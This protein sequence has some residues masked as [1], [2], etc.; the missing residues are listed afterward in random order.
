MAFVAVT[1]SSPFVHL[2]EL[3]LS[4]EA[5]IPEQLGRQQ[6]AII[7]RKGRYTYK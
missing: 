5:K 3:F 7:G 6:K 1:S 4:F 2:C